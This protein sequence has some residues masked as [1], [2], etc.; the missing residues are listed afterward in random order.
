MKKFIDNRNYKYENQN[1]QSNYQSQ[2]VEHYRNN[3][4]N[5]KNEYAVYK[6]DFNQF[7]ANQDNFFNRDQ[8]QTFAFAFQFVASYQFNNSYYDYKDKQ[9]VFTK[10][11][12]QVS[13]N[14]SQY[15]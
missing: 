10:S 4:I 1:Y 15:S 5:S 12:I 8:F 2:I 3:D 7:Y 13:L 11:Q 6:S 9:N 14:S